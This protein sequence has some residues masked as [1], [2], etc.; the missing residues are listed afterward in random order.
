MLE[1]GHYRFEGLARGAGIAPVNGDEKGAGAGLRISGANRPVSDKLVGDA[2]WT[3]LV[4][5]FD[6]APPL[7]SV[8]LVCELRATRGEV[9]FD[10]DSL[11]LV[12]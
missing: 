4:F 6:V 12:R 8:E 11:R 3:K 10:A 5:E 2:N 1:G 7:N 9:W